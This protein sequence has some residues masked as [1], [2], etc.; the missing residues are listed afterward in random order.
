MALSQYL[1][2]DTSK[3]KVSLD[4]AKKFTYVSSPGIGRRAA[5]KLGDLGHCSPTQLFAF[6][7][8]FLDALDPLPLPLRTPVI[9]TFDNPVLA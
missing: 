2:S 7:H 5:L 8:M 4:Q 1:W 9:H 6:E 3:P